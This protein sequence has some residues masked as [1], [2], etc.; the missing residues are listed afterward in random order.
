MGSLLS[1]SGVTKPQR[2]D[3]GS[4]FFDWLADLFQKFNDHSH[5][6]ANSETISSSSIIAVSDDITAADSGWSAVTDGWSITKTIP[7]SVL[8]NS[9]GI[10]IRDND[11]PYDQLY[12]DVVKTNDT[13]YTITSTS[14]KN[15]KVL[16]CA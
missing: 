13:D 4:D 2:G 1:P 3:T 7:E 14:K 5:D 8:I 15:L 12:L 16:F 11:S 9:V 6:G 10:V